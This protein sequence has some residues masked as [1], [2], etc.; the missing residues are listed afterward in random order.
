VAGEGLS[1][2]IV[3]ALPDAGSIKQL[4]ERALQLARDRYLTPV[5]TLERHLIVARLLGFPRTVIDVGGVPGQLR[6]ALPA[7]AI[8]A[9]NVQPPADLLVDPGPL[10]FR[11]HSVEAVTSLDTLEHV[12]PADRA[13]FVAELLRIAADRL[14]LCCP[15]GGPEHAAAERAMQAWHVRVAGAPHPW[16]EEHLEHGLP[17]LGDLERWVNAATGPQNHVEWGFH[18]DFRRLN[19]QFRDFVLASAS[20]SPATRGRLAAAR[21]RHVP[22]TALRREPDP[23]VNRVFVRVDRRPPAAARAAAPGP[24]SASS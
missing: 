13:A 5:D 1:T 22:D 12:P 19:E 11:D 8:T 23:W 17:E 2:A 18:G 9:V 15:L 10:P 14:V 6:G 21:L 7:T 4:G 20:R 24:G 3:P 16:L